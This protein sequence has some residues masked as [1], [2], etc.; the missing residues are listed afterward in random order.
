MEIQN[1]RRRLFGSIRPPQLRK[2][3]LTVEEICTCFLNCHILPQKRL[4]TTTNKVYYDLD[5]LVADVNGWNA[6]NF[7]AC[8]IDHN[9]LEAVIEVDSDGTPE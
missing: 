1:Q 7:F 8:G 3:Y 5:N 4:Q 2:K 9:L 6:S